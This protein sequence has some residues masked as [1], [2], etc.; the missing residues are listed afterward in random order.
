MDI[1]TSPRAANAKIVMPHPTVLSGRP[2]A[3]V[4]LHCFVR[5]SAIQPV[6]HYTSAHPAGWFLGAKMM[7]IADHM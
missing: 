4:N 1:K 5:A 6:G 7:A 2:Y 3:K